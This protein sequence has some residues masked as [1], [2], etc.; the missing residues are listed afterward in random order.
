MSTA[1]HGVSPNMRATSATRSKQRWGVG[2]GG[3]LFPIGKI[4]YRPFRDEVASVAID[5]KG[6]NGI[7]K[8]AL[9][10]VQV[11]QGTHEGVGQAGVVV[12]FV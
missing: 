9:I 4:G 5:M 6:N 2:G 3:G 10:V 1:R 11:Y 12:G 8:A 7:V